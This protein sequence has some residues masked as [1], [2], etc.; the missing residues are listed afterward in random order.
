MK[1]RD[2]LTGNFDDLRSRFTRLI[3]EDKNYYQGVNIMLTEDSSLESVL[4]DKPVVKFLDYEII[5]CD[6]NG[7]ELFITIFN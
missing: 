3:V 7:D 4:S 5:S 6:A 1:F 2:F